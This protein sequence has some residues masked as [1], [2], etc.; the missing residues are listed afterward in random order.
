MA[1]TWNF[2]VAGNKFQFNRR[3]CF[4]PVTSLL[5]A[6]LS[7]KERGEP[8]AFCLDFT[9]EEPKVIPADSFSPLL[10]GE[11]PGVRSKQKKQN[12]PAT[13]CHSSRLCYGFG[14]QAIRNPQSKIS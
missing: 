10:V 6:P 14:R 12:P 5:P 13:L 4:T 2:V 3:D 9:T 1:V 7:H 11:G 8:V